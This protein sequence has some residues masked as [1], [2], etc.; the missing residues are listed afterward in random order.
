MSDRPSEGLSGQSA[1]VTGAGSGIGKSIAQALAAAGVGVI[2]NDV[3]EKAATAV[4]ES[5]RSTGAKAVALA[6]DVSDEA[7]VERLFR[8][9]IEELGALDILVSNAGIQKDASFLEMSIQEWTRV[10]SVNLTGGFLC[11]RAAARQFVRQ[12]IRAG[13]SRSAGKILFTSSVHQVIPWT[14]HVNYAASKGGLQQLM[15]SVAQELAP[16]RIRVNAVAPGAIETAINRS[17]WSTEEARARLL[18]LI[19]YGRVG[20]P[21]DIARA[22]LWLVSDNADYVQGATLFVDGG[23]T[24]YPGFSEG[25]G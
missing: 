14:G 10:I 17:A 1:I 25:H 19:P 4:A 22:A 8:G 11:A 20:E 7:A 24:L 6:A 13:V 21:E 5:L 18:E 2:V 15:R 16:H 12:G 23:M 9:A 3:S